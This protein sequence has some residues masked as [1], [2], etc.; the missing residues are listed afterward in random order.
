MINERTVASSKRSC[1][2]YRPILTH[3]VSHHE[4]ATDQMRNVRVLLEGFGDVDGA[5][6]ADTVVLKVELHHRTVYL[7]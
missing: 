1:R 5:F 2:A 3:D 4:A 6:R 7:Q